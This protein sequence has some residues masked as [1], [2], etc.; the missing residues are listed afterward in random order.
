MT[1]REAIN[2]V[3]KIVPNNKFT[4]IEK[5]DWL[6]RLDNQIY[7][8]IID[9]REDKKAED[10]YGYNCNTDENT[11]LLADFPYD[12]LYIFFLKSQIHLYIGEMAQYSEN[13]SVFNNM[14]SQYRNYYNRHHKFADVPLK[15]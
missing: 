7:K 10:F 9:I 11:Q 15:F 12:E 8:E 6:S 5:T 2:A 13:V 4:D 14:L 1:I 3:N